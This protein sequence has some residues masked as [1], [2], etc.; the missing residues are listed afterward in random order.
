MKKTSELMKEVLMLNKKYKLLIGKINFKK[1]QGNLSTLY[2]LNTEFNETF[3]K[4]FDNEELRKKYNDWNYEENCI[5]FNKSN[6]DLLEELDEKDLE[7]YIEFYENY[8]ED[9]EDELNELRT[10]I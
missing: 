6:N 3:D 7:Q 9:L 10:H 1:A 5:K 8:I 2:N 4:F